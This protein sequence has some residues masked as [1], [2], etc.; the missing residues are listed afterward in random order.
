MTDVPPDH[1]YHA[2][3]LTRDELQGLARGE[4]VVAPFHPGAIVPCRGCGWHRVDFV[5]VV[6]LGRPPIEDYGRLME[7]GYNVLNAAVSD[8]EYAKLLGG[9][10]VAPTF[11]YNPDD[12]GELP[13]VLSLIP[14]AMHEA[15]AKDLKISLAWGDRLPPAEVLG[16]SSKV[17]LERFGGRGA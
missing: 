5:A 2:V 14:P 15:V 10:N 11:T 3:P 1:R 9:G 8:E 16:P 17:T 4:A 13:I 7:R 6:V 12:L